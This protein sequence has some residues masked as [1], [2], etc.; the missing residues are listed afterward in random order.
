MK[1]RRKEFLNLGRRTRGRIKTKILVKGKKRKRLKRNRMVVPLMK[2]VKEQLINSGLHLGGHP[3]ILRKEMNNYVVGKREGLC[4][5]DLMG[6][7]YYLRR[8]L[9]YLGTVVRRRVPVLCVLSKKEGKDYLSN[10]LVKAGHYAIKGRYVPGTI[11]NYRSVKV[12]KELPGVVCIADSKDGGYAIREC[13]NLEL[14]YFGL[15]DSEMDPNWFCFPVFGNNDS[16]DSS[17]LLVYLVYETIL[18]Q[19]RYL[20]R[21]FYKVD[22]KWKRLLRR[23]RG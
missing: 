21:K 9:K 8:G 12:M 22:L 20:K 6:S 10:F 5:I 1:K 7:V 4:L 16:T 18:L 14:P 11:S 15:C 2:I 13:M 3:K 17:R 19:E 23:K